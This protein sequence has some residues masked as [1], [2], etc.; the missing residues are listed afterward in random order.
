[1]LEGAV[2]VWLV[3]RLV[4]LI[5]PDCSECTTVGHFQGGQTSVER[6]D[7]FEAWILSPQW[8]AER[9]LLL[10]LPYLTAIPKPFQ[11]YPNVLTTGT[12]PSTNS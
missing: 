4:K 8:T 1:M 7:R 12:R 6:R 2:V 11:Q 10:S 3:I 9:S 5:S